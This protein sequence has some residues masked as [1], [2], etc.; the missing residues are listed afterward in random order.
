MT[1]PRKLPEHEIETWLASHADWTLRYGK[2][3]RE[4]RFADFIAAFGFMAK[5][6]VLAER[7]GHHPDWSN[8]YA[9]VVVDLV[10]H[11]VGGISDLDLRLAEE[12]DDC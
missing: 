11:D 10:T 3:H 1:A 9:R 7:M 12:I 5:V 8:S 4:L 2:L 6:A